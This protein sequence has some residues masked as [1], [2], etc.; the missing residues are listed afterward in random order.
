MRI[1]S[2]RTLVA[3]ALLV[4]VL[5]FVVAA[6]GPAA[7]H[8]AAPRHELL[9]VTLRDRATEPLSPWRARALLQRAGDYWS[10][11]LRG[12]GL[13]FVV[14]QTIELEVPDA[15]TTD[16]AA[17]W[18]SARRDGRIGEARPAQHIA[19]LRPAGCNIAGPAGQA[20]NGS[21]HSGGWL[22]SLADA[23]TLVHEL[24]HNLGLGHAAA[25]V[26]KQLHEYGGE[27]SPMAAVGNNLRALDVALLD[28][29][30]AAG[31][32]TVR[33]A[34][35]TGTAHTL[36]PVEGLRGRR[37][38]TFT[39]AATGRTY[40]V[41]YRTAAPAGLRVYY[42]NGLGT[43]T[44]ANRGNL[45][46][47]AGQMHATGDFTLE[48]TRT[49]NTARVKLHPPRHAPAT[50]IA[51][52]SS[53]HSSKSRVTH[54]RVRVVTPGTRVQGT[55]TVRRKGAVVARARVVNG[56]A[57]VRVP[58]RCGDARATLRVSFKPAKSAAASAAK[59]TWRSPK[60]TRSPARCQ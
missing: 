33:A 57:W 47:R 31:P 24:G 2:L 54:L 44:L 17:A 45:A 15:C 52:T 3:R 38:L 18:A 60:G 1:V 34:T 9:P 20:S 36:W 35:A 42:L 41:E 51:V 13:T 56:T 4:A 50:R 32:G 12:L 21:L 7:S 14:S 27:H 8:A 37:A 6:A 30:G 26:G 5:L 49:G 19:L 46:T 10:E 29:L 28:S 59:A 48:V 16:Y 11:Q 40:W 55:V 22:G 43:V 25:L 39:G 58:A 53:R 23:P